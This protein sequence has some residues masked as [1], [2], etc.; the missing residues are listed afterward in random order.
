MK[1]PLLA[2][3][4]FL[5]IGIVGCSKRP[6]PVVAKERI[7]QEISGVG[8]SEMQPQELT[9]GLF[10][11]VISK[12]PSNTLHWKL[13][14]GSGSAMAGE[15]ALPGEKYTYYFDQEKKIF[16]FATVRAISSM[17]VS[18]W[19]ST[20]ISSKGG[21][22]RGS[23]EGFESYDDLPPTFRDNIRRILK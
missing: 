17:N 22:I 10:F 15:V 8:S 21:G 12:S 11:S 9:D 1:I 3:L 23:T 4:A 20:Q 6:A 5:G 14:K 16:W 7:A 19:T 13:T 18:G 2:S